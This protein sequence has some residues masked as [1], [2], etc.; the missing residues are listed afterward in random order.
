MWYTREFE[1]LYKH[2]QQQGV[3]PGLE[4]FV[5]NK[6]SGLFEMA[7]TGLQGVS[8]L[9]EEIRNPNA[10]IHKQIEQTLLYEFGDVNP[11]AI[12]AI[13]RS[14]GNKY[15]AA[16]EAIVGFTPAGKYI[17]QTVTEGKVENAY[18]KY[19]RPTE[20]PFEAVQRSKDFGHL[21]QL[22]E[23]GGPAYD[24]ALDQA[25]KTY[26]MTPKDVGKLEK[27]FRREDNYD[28]SLAMFKR[29]D[30]STQKSLLDQM[31]P[32]EREKYLP[33]SNKEHLRHHYEAP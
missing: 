30:W 19:V 28:P 12:E 27:S 32:A 9:G 11:I 16:A 33:A 6:G 24:Q 8:S 22:Y 15:K 7:K 3:V 10:P 18:N 31:T 1:G 21:A 14:T 25:I 23:K 17:S 4:D 13:N 2:M 5:L 29:L 20:K 26:Q